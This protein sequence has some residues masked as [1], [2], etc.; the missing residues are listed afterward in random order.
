M[1]VALSVYVSCVWVWDGL[2]AAYI[3]SCSMPGQTKSHRVNGRAHT[4]KITM[5]RCSLPHGSQDVR[6]YDE[7]TRLRL[8]K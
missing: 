7:D 1:L 2:I 4:G 6:A 3:Q 5:R 8:N